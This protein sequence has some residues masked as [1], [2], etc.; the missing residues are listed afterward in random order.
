MFTNFF[1]RMLN[2]GQALFQLII[3]TLIWIEFSYQNDKGKLEPRVLSARK[4][5]KAADIINSRVDIPY[6]GEAV[7]AV[8]LGWVIDL[9]VYTFNSIVSPT[10]LE[11]L[12][13][14]SHEYIRNE[15]F[16]AETFEEFEAIAFPADTKKIQEIENHIITSDNEVI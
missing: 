7:E 16:E 15:A 13:E 11:A 1:K 8:I 2:K 5:E 4:Q 3:L 9:I 14:G 12:M 6:L 10:W